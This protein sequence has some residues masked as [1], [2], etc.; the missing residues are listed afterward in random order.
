MPK[1]NSK[2]MPDSM[3]EI[4]GQSDSPQPTETLASHIITARLTELDTGDMLT[5]QHS[6]HVE[7]PRL[8]PFS[9]FLQPQSSSSLLPTLLNFVNEN[10]AQVRF[11]NF[12]YFLTFFFAFLLQ[13]ICF[14]T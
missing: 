14:F 3:P 5:S 9:F 7:A 12:F 11:Y 6:D 10:Q 8:P 13:V 1:A 4:A 2:Q